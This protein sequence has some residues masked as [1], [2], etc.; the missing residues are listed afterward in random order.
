MGGI[1]PTGPA[2]PTGL[3]GSAGG[4]YASYDSLDSA[5]DSDTVGGTGAAT[6]DQA[7]P[8]PTGGSHPATP[9]WLNQILGVI[10]RRIVARYTDATDRA[11]RRSARAE[12]EVTYLTAD[13][14]LWIRNA[15]TDIPIAQV[16]VS[17]S[18]P[19]AGAF[20]PGTIWAQV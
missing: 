12:G 10:E 14:S 16:L 15:T 3:T 7:I 18:G 13:D 17:T 11:A 8:V 2:G 5:G 20:P 19:G 9:F 1:G 6:A 4:G